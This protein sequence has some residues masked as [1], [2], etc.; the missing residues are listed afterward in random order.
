[1]NE[2]ESADSIEDRVDRLED[3]MGDVS[4]QDLEERLQAIET[5][6]QRLESNID[7]LAQRTRQE[8]DQTPHIESVKQLYRSLEEIEAYMKQVG[9]QVDELTDDSE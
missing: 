6:Q 7:A 2:D 4:I 9:E 5:H 3:Q 1:V 8:S